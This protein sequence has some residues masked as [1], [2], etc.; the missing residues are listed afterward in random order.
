MATQKGL[1]YNAGKLKWGL[2]DYKAL[3]PMVRVLMYGAHKYSLFKNKSG[4][5][6]KGSQISEENAYKYL[7]YYSGA[8]NWK[9]GLDK[10]EI[11]ECAMRHLALLMDGERIDKES[12]LP[13]SGHI[14]CNMMFYSYFEQ[15]PELFKKKL[16]TKKK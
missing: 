9:N 14:L 13:H 16:K 15:L 4:K 3:E 6:I 7:L 2:V 12:K 1:R 11:L 8:N 10:R 5:I